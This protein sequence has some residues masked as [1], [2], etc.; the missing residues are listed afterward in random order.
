MFARRLAI[1]YQDIETL[2]DQQRRV[3]NNQTEAQ[4]EHVVARAHLE[5]RAN[6][7]LR[8]RQPAQHQESLGKSHQS[9]KLLAIHGRK[10]PRRHH[11]SALLEVCPWGDEGRA[12]LGRSIVSKGVCARHRDC[13][14][15]DGAAWGKYVA[16]AVWTGNFQYSALPSRRGEVGRSGPPRANSGAA[17]PMRLD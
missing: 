4:R 17:W 16:C 5:E 2:L 9:V 8:G 6:R 7:S 14:P 13:A 1:L 10:R 3:E 15:L 11:R 12:V